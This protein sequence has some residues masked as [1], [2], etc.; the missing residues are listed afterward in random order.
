MH[1]LLLTVL[2][3]NSTALGLGVRVRVIAFCPFVHR[4]CPFVHILTPKT[5]IFKRLY[6]F[7]FWTFLIEIPKFNKILQFVSH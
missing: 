5:D 7:F 6:N 1:I 2:H 3:W 4:F